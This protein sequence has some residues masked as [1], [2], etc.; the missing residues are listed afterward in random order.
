[1]RIKICCGKNREKEHIIDIGVVKLGTDYL[2]IDGSFY[3]TG[4]DSKKIYD[5]LFEKGY[6]DLTGYKHDN[7]GGY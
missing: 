7:P 1:M 3:E 2:K 4:A 6:A 5:E